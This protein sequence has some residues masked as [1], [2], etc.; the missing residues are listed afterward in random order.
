MYNDNNFLLSNNFNLNDSDCGIIYNYIIKNKPYEIKFYFGYSE[1]YY[2][3]KYQINSFTFLYIN[4]SFSL[5][6]PY[7]LHIIIKD[8]CKRTFEK[9]N[10][11][12]NFFYYDDMVKDGNFFKIFSFFEN[13]LKMHSSF[14]ELNFS[15][16]LC[17]F[18][19][20]TKNNDIK[21]KSSTIKENYFKNFIPNFNLN[22]PLSLDKNIL[23]SLWETDFLFDILLFSLDK[24]KSLK[25]G[26]EKKL[27]KFIKNK[28]NNIKIDISKFYTVWGDSY[29]IINLDNI[30]YHDNEYSIEFKFHLEALCTIIPF[31]FRDDFFEIEISL[32]NKNNSDN[33]FYI[34]TYG[35]RIYNKDNNVF[36]S[37]FNNDNKKMTK[38]NK[39]DDIFILINNIKLFCFSFYFQ[40]FINK[41]EVLNNISLKT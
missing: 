16:Q 33:I 14:H 31:E 6:K 27:I 34:F 13:I 22:F 21:I 5:S 32:T 17:F 12:E 7:R 39:N 1:K 11:I 10:L 37:V 28:L 29:A 36:V 18:D 24:L 26:S 23:D 41:F 35:K 4:I 2:Y 30:Y 40:K 25:L 9:K 20:V 3:F 8:E 15:E 38:I 19:N